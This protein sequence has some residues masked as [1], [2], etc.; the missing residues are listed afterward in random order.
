MVLWAPSQM[1]E[2]YSRYNTLEMT[3]GRDR[4]HHRGI[5]RFGAPEPPWRPGSTGSRSKSPTTDCCAAS[6]LRFFNRR[7]DDYGGSF[8]NRMRLPLEVV[9]AIKRE[10]GRNVPFGVRMCL[11]EYTLLRVRP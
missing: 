4:G 7:E 3:P 9:G 6:S 8:E 2:P 5:R 1:P 11:H 10:I